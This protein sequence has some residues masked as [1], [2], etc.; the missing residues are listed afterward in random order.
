MYTIYET[1]SSLRCAP[2]LNGS[3]KDIKDMVI[4]NRSS[5]SR[6]WI[7]VRFILDAS[8]Y[9]RLFGCMYCV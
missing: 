3:S 9:F 8:V 6:D 4:T 1:K 2:M 7:Q 5:L